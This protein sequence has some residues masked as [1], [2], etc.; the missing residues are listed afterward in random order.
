MNLPPD[1]RREADRIAEVG[2]SYG[3]DFFDTLFELVSFEQLNEVAALGGFPIRYPHWRFGMEFERLTKGHTYGLSRIYEL[4]VNNNPCYA[5]LL[6]TNPLVDQ[7]LVMAHVYGHCD[8]FKNN[9]NFFRTNRRMIDQ[10]ANHGG[11]VRRYIDR[12][13][14]EKVESFLDSV[15]S[16][17]NLIDPHWVTAERGP[18]AGTEENEAP[19]EVHKLPSKEYMDSFVN[20]ENFL[21]E[22]RKRLEQ[23]RQRRRKFPD[24][25]ERDVLWFL[26]EYAPLERWQR[27]VLGIIREESYYFA[28]QTQ[29]KIM[30]E[31]WASYWHSRIMTEKVLGDDEVVDYADHCAGVFSMR[32]GTFNPYKVGLELWR[33]LERRWDLGQFGKEY[34]ECDDYDMKASWDTNTGLGQEKI[35]EVRRIYNDVTFIDEFLTPQFCNDNQLFVSAYNERTK[36]YEITDRDF[37]K[38]KL[39]LLWHLTNGGQ[40]II[41]VEDGNFE[42]KGELLLVHDHQGVDLDL[43]YAEGTLKNIQAIWGRPVNIQTAL[44]GKDKI[45]SHD[46]EKFSDRDI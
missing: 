23:E 10:M 14:L 24:R 31:G 46:G 5:Y 7:K 2:R 37:K 4:V 32:P 25:P 44:G 6:D 42:N 22:Q 40:P 1:L 27:D 41:R 12:F 26:M 39:Q 29:T 16:I 20:P 8:F 34:D 35:F 38:V 15:L 36:R 9:I 28:P 43:V 13:G 30:N 33:D 11:R 18:K 45:F 21:D 3:L 17:E 19:L